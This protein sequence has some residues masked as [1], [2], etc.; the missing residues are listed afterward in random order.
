MGLCAA[1]RAFCL[2]SARASA[3]LAS[4]MS[5]LLLVLVLVLHGGLDHV[6]FA[7]LLE[8]AVVVGLIRPG[9]L[10]MFEPALLVA[11][12][13]LRYLDLDLAGVFARLLPAHLD[14]RHTSFSIWRRAISSASFTSA[15]S[16]LR[17]SSY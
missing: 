5:V 4:V 16:S 9:P 3:S 12:P 17:M 2:A 14:C 8:V 15:C 7:R 10:V 13:L 11:L 1:S 6:A